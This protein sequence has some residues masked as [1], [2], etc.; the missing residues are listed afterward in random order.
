MKAIAANMATREVAILA[1][2]SPEA[3]TAG[4]NVAE[5]S[6]HTN[7]LI[8]FC[9]FM[10]FLPFSSIAVE[11]IVPEMTRFVNEKPPPSRRWFDGSLTFKVLR[12]DATS[13]A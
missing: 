7:R 3:A 13:T 11:S 9:N 8:N 4:G 6:P 12:E 5:L 2:T 10:N 1:G